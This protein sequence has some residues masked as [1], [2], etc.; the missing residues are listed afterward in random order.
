MTRCADNG[1]RSPRIAGNTN[2]R[3]ALSP[4]NRDHCAANTLASIRGLE[5]ALAPSREA[6]TSTFTF[7]VSASFT[8]VVSASNR[9]I[10]GRDE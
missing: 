3:K 10:H 1:G 2:G 7:A 4:L 5:R 9:T 6:M 8:F